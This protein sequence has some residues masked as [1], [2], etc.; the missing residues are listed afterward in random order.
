[1]DIKAI[2]RAQDEAT[3]IPIIVESSEGLEGSDIS[4][5]S[6]LTIDCIEVLGD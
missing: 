5:L 6:D 4:S 3:G 2:K 1:M